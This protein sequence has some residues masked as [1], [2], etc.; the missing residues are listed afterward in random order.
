MKMQFLVGIVLL[1]A[2]TGVLAATPKDSAKSRGQLLYENHCTRCHETSVH[3]RKPIRV[4][5]LDDLYHW[6]EKWASVQKLGW[7]QDEVRDVVDYLN[8]EYYQLKK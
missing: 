2:A 5:N 3:S 6:V 8:H 4:T 1:S 7:N